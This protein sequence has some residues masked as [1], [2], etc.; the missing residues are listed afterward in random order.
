MQ[1]RFVLIA[2]AAC[3]PFLGLVALMNAGNDQRSLTFLNENGAAS[4][5][6]QSGAIKLEGPFFRSLGTNGRSCATCHQASDNWSVTPSHLRARFENTQGTDPIFRV[7]DGSNCDTSDVSTV[8]ARRSAY[9]MLL[10]KGLIRIALSVPQNAEFT[11]ASVSNPYGCDSKTVVSVYRRPLP[12]T[13]LRFLTT[14]MWDGRE[15]T[16]GNTLEQ[17]L[18]HQAN[19][20]TLG[21]A[22]G[23]VDL[24]DDEK[25]QIVDFEMNLTTAQVARSS[26]GLLNVQGANGG[27]DKLSAQP[28]FVGTNDP[29]GT[30]V[31]TPFAFSLF[32]EWKNL[33]S[34]GHEPSSAIRESIARGEQLFNSKA[35]QIRDVAGLNDLPGLS[36]V[37]GTCTTCHNTP[38]VGNHSV[39]LSIN[40]GI[41]DSSRRTPDL[42]LFVLAR[43][44]TGESVETTDPGR[45]LITGKWNDIGKTKGPILRGLS[46]RAP[47]FHNGSAA[48]LQDIV[49]FYDSRFS[50]G[51]TEQEKADLVNFLS[52]I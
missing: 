14:V 46:G 3:S 41:A 25:K 6:P 36:V 27:S 50:V 52:S 1:S 42:P 12:S 44:G 19:D 31:F 30:G 28:F 39:P 24:T 43:K 45:A 7:V 32:T 29:L 34:S 10:N 37:S 2:M 35:I 18:M 49:N 38:N 16:P 51:F 21:H 4:T 26:I 22:Q 8:D 13:N 15:S 48:T 17:N 40:I 23:A 20:A 9:S 11:V 5:V 33:H 47:Y